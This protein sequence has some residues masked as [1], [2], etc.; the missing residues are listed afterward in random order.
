M[1]TMT[2]ITIVTRT[3]THYDNAD[4]DDNH[5]D[6]KCGNDTDDGDA[7]TMITIMT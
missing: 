6:D 2:M 5:N 4:T 1:M 7:M 3:L